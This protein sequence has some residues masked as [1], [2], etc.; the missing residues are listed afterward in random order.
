MCPLLE[1]RPMRTIGV[2]ELKEHTSRILEEVREKGDEVQI[3]RHGRVIARLVPV[4]PTPPDTHELDAVW[5]EM[6][7][8]A[9][10]IAR[11]WPE[12]ASATE[13]VSDGRLGP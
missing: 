10:E 13:A 5:S 1:V 7:K 11:H 6:D 9:D 4:L 3:T 8:L 2:R 12:G